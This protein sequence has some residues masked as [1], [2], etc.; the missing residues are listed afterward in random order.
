MCLQADKI[1]Q[2]P[3]QHFKRSTGIINWSLKKILFFGIKLLIQIIDFKINSSDN[4]LLK[5]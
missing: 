1:I 5:F 2:I 3:V 4:K